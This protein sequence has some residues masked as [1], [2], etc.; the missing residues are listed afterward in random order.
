MNSDVG[1]SCS[2]SAAVSFAG[3]FGDVGGG[4]LDAE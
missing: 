1:T 2:I 3:A 4:L